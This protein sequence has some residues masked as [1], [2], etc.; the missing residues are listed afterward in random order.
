MLA[1]SELQPGSQSSRVQE[2]FQDMLKDSSTLVNLGSDRNSAIEYTPINSINFPFAEEMNQF[3]KGLRM[4][5]F[6]SKSETKSELLAS[7][8]KNEHKIDD[9]GIFEEK[10]LLCDNKYCLTEIVD[11]LFK[12][13]SKKFPLEYCELCFEAYKNNQFCLYCEGLYLN[14][15][16]FRDSDWIGCDFCSNWV[17]LFKIL[18]IP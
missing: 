18:M 1:I 11:Q 10:A 3:E 4:T 17:I 2:I 16:D 14:D 12:T 7:E 15:N 5:N 6:C 9:L 13:K 8:H